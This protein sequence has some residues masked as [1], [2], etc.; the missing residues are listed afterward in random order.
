MEAKTKQCQNCK[1]DF[2][3]ELE[4]FEFYEKFK[5]T[6][7]EFCPHCRLL[8]RLNWRNERT[9]YPRQCDLCQKKMLSIYNI[10]HSFPVYCP[11]CWYSDKWDPMEYGQR[12]DW[13]KPFFQ[14]FGELGEKV[15]RLSLNVIDVENCPYVQQCWHSKNCYMCFDLG[16]G[17]NVLYSK[18]CHYLTDS[19]D[20]SY[21]K[22]IELCYEST[23]AKDSSRS[24]YLLNCQTCL[25]SYFLKNCRNCSD[26]I[27]CVNLRNKK[28]HILN[29]PYSKK[30]YEKIK[31][32][33]IDGSFSKY[34]KAK[35][36]FDKIVKQA[37]HKEN[38]NL[39]A[40]DCIGNHIWQSKD[41]KYCFNM[42]KSENCRYM[43]DVD[44]DVKDAMDVSNAAEGEL[45][46]NSSSAGD[47]SKIIGS[48]LAAGGHDIYH[49]I[50][51]ARNDTNLFGCISLNSKKYCILN[52]QYTK[53]EY[54]KLFPK[55]KE[56]MTDLPYRDGKGRRYKYGDFF[57][58]DLSPY[59]Y[60]ETIAQEFFPLTKDQA[61]SQGYQWYDRP[62]SEHKPTIKASDLPDS[63]KDVNN[64][65]LKE[66]IECG[67]KKCSGSGV[68][69][70]IPQELKFYREQNLPLPRL[71]P[72]CRHQKRI[73][74]RNPW[75]L[76]HRK[77]MKKGCN[78]EFETTYSPDR[79]EIIYCEKCYN[80]A[81]N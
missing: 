2:T 23:N 7:P 44:S 24:A 16:Y 6:P 81:I 64:N 73:E 69:K 29:K 41:C 22:K 77:C 50:L 51:C 70:M 49:S 61:L 60:N 59:G 13:N 80:E 37:I 58:L 18:A 43:N 57:P 72:Y 14:Q 20:C 17:E 46:Y 27:L 54:E 47:G 10:D 56:H 5:V 8:I 38:E 3:I 32:E 11:D 34:K 1:S 28:H 15:P 12:Y 4:D 78:T 40:I 30:E 55:I 68:F 62:E 9:L 35:E 48:W 39:K 53:G 65:V 21:C 66:V 36:L 25:D 74:Q 52:K 79:K 67:S 31:G 76:W 33:Y 19:V 71:C 26:C 45:L 63:I 75:Q 42:F